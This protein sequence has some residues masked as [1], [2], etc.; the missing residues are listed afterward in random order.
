MSEP[1]GAAPAI[2][3]N[4][5]FTPEAEWWTRCAT[6]GLSEAA[7]ETTLVCAACGGHGTALPPDRFG[8]YDPCPVCDGRG[9]R[10]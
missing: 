6:C 7:H 5:P 8:N 2:V 1:E 3:R 10:E 9:V 4:H